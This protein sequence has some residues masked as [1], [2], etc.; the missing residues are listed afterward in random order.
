MAGWGREE[1]RDY[2]CFLLAQKEKIFT[3]A[4]TEDRGDF[5]NAKISTNMEGIEFLTVLRI[6]G[7]D[8]IFYLDQT[9][10]T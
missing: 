2:L 3:T 6:D 5:L 4:D 1:R 7:G 8:K 9:G 10:F